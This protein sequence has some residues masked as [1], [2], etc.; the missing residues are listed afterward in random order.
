MT[1]DDVFSPYF[2][3]LKETSLDDK[4]SYW[5]SSSDMPV[6]YFDA[7]KRDYCNRYGK[8]EEASASV[9][10][11]FMHG[12]SCC[13]VEFKH[14]DSL[15]G[16][17]VNDIKR[18]LHDSLLIFLDMMKYDLEYSRDNIHFILV[19]TDKCI[20]NHE[21]DQINGKKSPS[22]NSMVESLEK[23]SKTR[24]TLYGLGLQEKVFVNRVS[25]LSESD[26]NN[27]FI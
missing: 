17:Q 22:L 16:H 6:V 20:R 8:S 12:E 25:T 14:V 24:L 13:F 23:L 11:V 3:T 1:F 7:V 10:A 27:M 18:K 9:D 19:V 26:F 21:T 5:M 4:N 2:R 15:N